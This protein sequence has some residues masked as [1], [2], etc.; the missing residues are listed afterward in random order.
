MAKASQTYGADELEGSLLAMNTG[1]F[2]SVE[3]LRLVAE[4]G[5]TEVVD[6]ALDD[7][8]FRNS[9]RHPSGG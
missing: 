1:A 9:M 2:G 4:K 5:L 7:S 8:A 3:S 6:K